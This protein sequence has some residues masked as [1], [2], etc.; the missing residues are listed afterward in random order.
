[1]QKSL[2]LILLLFLTCELHANNSRIGIQKALEIS[3]NQQVTSQEIAKIYVALCNNLMEPSFYQER[4]KAIE[5]FDEQLHQLSQFTPNEEIKDNIQNLRTIWVE[6]KK[7][8]SWTIKKEAASKLLKQSTSILQASK[9]LYLAYYNYNKSQTTASK[10]SDLITIRQY[11]K[12]NRNQLILMQRIML[13]YLAEKQGIGTTAAGHSLNDAQKAFSRSLSILEKAKITSKSIQ[14]K[15]TLVRGHWTEINQHLIFVDKNQSYVNDMLNRSNLISNIVREISKNYLELSI[16]LNISYSINEAT[17]QTVYVQKI[18]KS[19]IA[20][21]N[22]ET[23]YKYKKE[24]TE[25]IADFERKMNSMLVTAQT[26]DIKTSV[27]V[28]KTMWKNY[29]KLAT[30]FE[31]MNDIRATKLIE[32]SYVVMAACDRVSDEIETYALKF[33]AYK[34]L[35]IKNGVKIDPSL[36]ITHQIYVS[37]VL[38]INSQRLA[39]YF[40]LSALDI[41]SNLSNKR[42]K[43][44]LQEFKN[45]FEELKASKINSSAMT[46]LLE[47]CNKQ[48][49]WMNTACKTTSKEDIDLMLEHTTLLSKKLVKLTNLYEHRMNDFFAQD[50]EEKEIEK[51]VAPAFIAPRN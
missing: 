26:E 40:I 29:K 27:K 10:N 36:D 45:Q 14:N 38:R 43:M 37:S 11:I 2:Y 39:L 24:V 12:Q 5:L 41:D 31:L 46:L 17:M 48:W 1:M 25:Y 4:D 9:A 20:A 49:D 3:S 34:A 28:V 7:I 32:Q 47:S 42:L 13:Y 16:K 19:Y 21:I 44:Y 8:A 33:P 23:S 6:Y 35:S 30:D 22:D 15:L 18:A 51:E 50:I